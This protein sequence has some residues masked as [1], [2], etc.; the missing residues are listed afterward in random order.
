MD[1]T[2]KFDIF[3]LKGG[4]ATDDYSSRRLVC[5][6]ATWISRERRGWFNRGPT[7]LRLSL[8]KARLNTG[9]LLPGSHYRL[10]SYDN[11]TEAISYGQL[12][13]YH[14]IDGILELTFL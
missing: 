2:V 5:S 6:E 9:L 7:V 1:A 12:L 3:L 13:S 10:A 4:P 8:E 11:H 14:I